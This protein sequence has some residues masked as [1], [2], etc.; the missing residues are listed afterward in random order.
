M[1]LRAVLIGSQTYGLSG[2][3]ADVELMRRVLADRGFTRMR[4]Y[5]EDAAGYHGIAGALERLRHET[6][7]GD[8][9]VVYYSGHGSMHG[10]LQYLVPVDIGQSTST[11]FR[12]YLAEEL[13]AAFRAITAITPNVTGILDC[14]HSGGMLRDSDQWQLKSRTLPEIPADDGLARAADHART[15]EVL[16]PHLVRLPASRRHGSAYEAANRQGTGRQGLF[17]ETLADLLDATRDR[18]LPWSVL[19]ARA[20]DRI[21]QRVAQW[22][23][24]GGPSGRLPFSLETPAQPERLPL[25]RRHGR[26]LVP[27]GAV[28]GLGPGDLVRMVFPGAGGETDGPVC[29]VDALDAGDAV[30]R[31]PPDAP[32]LLTQELPP[33]SYALPELVH[34]RWQVHIAPGATGPFAAELRERLTAS[35]RLAETSLRD[36]AFASVRVREDGS[37]EVVNPDDHAFRHPVEATATGA[38]DLAALLETLA[39]GERLR[40]LRDPEGTERLDAEIDAR[41]EVVTPGAGGPFTLAP[42]GDPVYD[43][44]RYRVVVT[45]R[46]TRVLYLWVLGVGLSGRTELVTND[47][48]SGVRLQPDDAAHGSTVELGP[49]EI[50]WPDD[51]P[52][53]GSRPET[54]H[55]LVGDR[56]MDLTPLV[57][58]GAH[59]RAMTEAG[60]SLRV[61]L[62][63]I[64]DG[65]RDQ[66][67][68]AEGEFRHR[69]LTVRAC[70]EPRMRGAGA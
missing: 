39:R 49:V 20:R 45:N 51:V 28:F 9:V 55:L 70:A 56:T 58:R 62:R 59:D 6:R 68:S 38:R 37:A 1:T 3:H 32:E 17:T 5:V 18:P 11:D 22:P 26:F 47:Q 23:D 41:F 66:R 4:T 44:D 64:W 33:G 36:G 63:E 67:P 16:V 7:P 14:C 2:V 48:P 27:G 50:Y 31:T 29:P 34:D 53:K 10:D 25:V 40:Q 19:I 15:P 30:L 46:S 21:G 57:S 13:T 35:P 52:R 54:V 43:G 8:G 65:V 61:L 60:P 24:A 69:V 42:E 12:G